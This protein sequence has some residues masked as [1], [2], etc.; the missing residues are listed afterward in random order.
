[1]PPESATVIPLRAKVRR[2]DEL[3]FLPAALEIVETP[4]SPLGR[5]IGATVIAFFCL[6]LAWATFGRVDIIATA[7]GRVIP[8]GN[9]KVIQPFETGV[10]RAI[11]VAEGQVVNAG[12]VLIELDPTANDADV[13]R[14]NKNLQQDRLDIARLD[15]LL[16]ADLTSFAPPLDA[17]LVLTDNARGQ[18][19][20][21]AAEQEAKLA[22][23]D[24]QIDQK[25]AEAEEAKAEIEK[26]EAVLPI[27]QDQRDIREKVMHM[28]FGSRLLFLQTEQQYIE[29]QHQLVAERHR[30]DQVTQALAALTR[31][32]AQ[33]EAEYRKS[34]LSDLAKAKT[35]ANEH[36]EDAV[37][38][39]QRREL[40]TLRSPLNGSVQQLA[41]HTI[42]GVVTPAQQLM[43]IVPREARLEIEANLANKDVGFVRPGQQVEVKVETFNFTRY[44]L[45]RGTVTTISHDVV[46]ADVS[47]PDRKDRQDDPALARSEE[48]RQA[49]QPSYVAHVALEQ[50]GIQ[51]ED[52]F[53]SL[54]PGMAVTAE[55]KTG[56][57][58][59]IEFLLSPLLRYRQE[60]WRER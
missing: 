4:A 5:A 7:S 22:G 29:Q 3:E 35:S 40:Q 16:K 27:L 42:G 6:A 11:H 51:T 25:I 10:V 34:L 32:R 43:V 2:R 57:R 13:R 36:G 45:L 58:R 18:M 31:Q 37:K 1:M 26:I 24:R 56:R 21:Q 20:A 47:A 49:R 33:T 12:D 23:L 30:L 48:E 44:G 50:T 19:E 59:V 9:T 60:A 8:S 55:I 39:I 41:I 38:A 14:S 15:A 17:A 54:E 28:E 46:A 53:A 52:G